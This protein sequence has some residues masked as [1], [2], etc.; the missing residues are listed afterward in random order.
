MSGIVGLF[1]GEK[2]MNDIGGKQHHSHSHSKPKGS[3][4]NNSP[5]EVQVDVYLH[6]EKPHDYTIQSYLQSNPSNPEELVFCNNGHNGF[7]V[8]FVLHDETGKGYGFPT[9]ANK[10]DAVWSEVGAGLCPADP[11][12]WDVFDKKS[13]TVGGNGATLKVHNPNPTPAQGQFSY[14]LN[15]TT[16]GGKPYLPL[17]PGG[18]NMNG[19]TGFN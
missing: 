16:T 1:R 4:Q 12:A 7:N 13:I 2:R 10:D 8:T 15:V 19:S 17:D 6:S 9:G 11:G 3:A 5:W 18:N 14:T